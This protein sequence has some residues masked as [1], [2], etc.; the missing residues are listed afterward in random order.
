M[1][2]A[3]EGDGTSGALGAV[4]GELIA[5]AY[6]NAWIGEVAQFV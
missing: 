6:V 3:M 4:V 2:F 1:D 5:D